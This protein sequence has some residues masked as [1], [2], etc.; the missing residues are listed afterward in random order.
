MRHHSIGIGADCNR[1]TD[2]TVRVCAGDVEPDNEDMEIEMEAGMRRPERKA[3]PEEPAEHML[4]HIPFR[5]W[6][7]HCVRGRGKEEP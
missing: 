3:A 2:D 5:S 4:T 7:R 6:C 1:K